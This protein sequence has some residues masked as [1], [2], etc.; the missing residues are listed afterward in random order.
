MENIIRVQ[1]LSQL[2]DQKIVAI[3]EKLLLK[4]GIF[5]LRDLSKE[6]EVSLAT[7]YRIVQKL[8]D[9]GLVIRERQGKIIFYK[10]L[11]D[12]AV[13]KEVYDLII[14][15]PF[16]VIEIFKKKLKEVN[17]DIKLIPHKDKMFVVGDID[18]SIVNNIVSKISEQADSQLNILVIST[19]QYEQMRK[20]GLISE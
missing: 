7:T 12:S 6:S 14:G 13:F 20:I 15:E 5:Y 9:I 11:R 18:Q 1:L 17:K 10:V 8:S 16:N 19:Q 2:F 4:K 3:I